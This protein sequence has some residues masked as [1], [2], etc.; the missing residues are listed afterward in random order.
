[1]N[2]DTAIT[3]EVLIEEESPLAAVVV[4]YEDSEMASFSRRLDHWSAVLKNSLLSDYEENRKVFTDQMLADNQKTKEEY[5]LKV[6][7]LEGKLAEATLSLE[8]ANRKLDTKE[9]LSNNLSLYYARREK[10]N[11]VRT[12]F[13]FWRD[14]LASRKGQNLSS[15]LAHKHYTNSMLRKIVKGWRAVVENTWKKSVERSVHREADFRIATAAKE[16]DDAIKAHKRTIDHLEMQLQDARNSLK[17]KQDD[18]RL[19][20]MRGVSALNAQALGIF[21]EDEGDNQR[22][23]LVPEGH[24]PFVSSASSPG[25]NGSGDFG[26]DHLYNAAASAGHLQH[27][28]SSH[29]LPPSPSSKPFKPSSKIVYAKNHADGSISSTSGLVTRHFAK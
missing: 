21:K 5:E 14:I 29:P 23:S 20:F 7:G 18:M 16:S 27:H 25:V 17:Q 28:P 26:G 9:Q 10:K 6:A 3:T 1:M 19:A 13:T 4:D 11:L 15:R 24:F 2:I 12:V 8:S 22:V